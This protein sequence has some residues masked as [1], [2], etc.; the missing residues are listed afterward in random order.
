MHTPRLVLITGNDLRHT[1]FIRRLNHCFPVEAVF[2]E[3]K[4]YPPLPSASEEARDAWDWFF[5]RRR[6]Y[7][8]RVFEPSRQLPRLNEPQTVHLSPGALNTDTTLERLQH[9]D[10]DLILLF[11]CGLVG[12]TLLERFSGRI[13]NLHVG[14]TE[15]YRGSSCNFW[16]IHDERLDCLGAT[17]LK[18]D[19]GI[20]TGAIVEEGRIDIEPGDDEQSLM[21]KTILLGVDLMIE[22]V[23]RW[24]EDR[25]ARIP[26]QGGT[27]CRRKDFD[28]S[29][30]LRVRRLVESPRWQELIAAA[31][32]G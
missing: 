8:Q 29:A 24:Q 9:I 12:S 6:R 23:Q 31:G 7:E 4:D 20:D 14:L 28:A 3:G 10:P 25:P 11:D 26:E 1:H 18:I 17:I 15:A 32:R 21:G 22:A 30:V 27:L 13:L 2:T 5:E 19:A 16:P